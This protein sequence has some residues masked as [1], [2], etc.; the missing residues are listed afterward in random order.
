MD[1]YLL[2]NRIIK[3]TIFGKSEAVPTF[4]TLGIVYPYWL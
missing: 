2:T 4:V 3:N 1:R